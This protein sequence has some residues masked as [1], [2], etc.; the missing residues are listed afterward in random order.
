MLQRR[1]TRCVSRGGDNTKTRSLLPEKSRSI[2]GVV[3][4]RLPTRQVLLLRAPAPDVNP[5]PAPACLLVRWVPAL[6][7]SRGRPAPPRCRRRAGNNCTFFLFISHF[8]LICRPLSRVVVRANAF[9]LGPARSFR[10]PGPHP[11]VPRSSAR[12][13][14][15][16]ESQFFGSQRLPERTAKVAVA[17]TIGPAIRVPTPNIRRGKPLQERPQLAVVLRTRARV[18]N[19]WASSRSPETRM[20]FL[21]NFS[22]MTR[23]KVA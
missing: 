21:A 22:R 3:P 13:K 15:G 7:A 12:L 23:S 19:G 10:R 18:A 20:G 14:G 1:E 6:A 4:H 8:S 11:R 5:R 9:R 2:A 17:A 16:F